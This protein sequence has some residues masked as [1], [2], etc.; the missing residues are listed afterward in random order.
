MVTSALAADPRADVYSL[1]VTLYEMLAGRRPFESDDPG[2][3]AMLQREMKPADVRQHRPEIPDEVA[4]L[5]ASMLAKDPM[6]RPDSA[7]E[8]AQ[9]LVRLEID[10]FALR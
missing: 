6:R 1:G 2:K 3:L 8:L 7:R 9:R 4:A 5:I 10:S